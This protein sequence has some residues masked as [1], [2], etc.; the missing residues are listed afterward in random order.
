MRLEL[1][2]DD[3][4]RLAPGVRLV[5]DGVRGKTFLLAPEKAI[6]L[7]ATGCAIL[8]RIT[9]QVTFAEI[10][11]D[12]ATAYDAPASEIEG[13]VQQYLMALRARMYVG[14]AP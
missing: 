11:R 1:A 8:G 5:E 2:A 3:R 7:D 14:V 6:E 10:V 4:P 12:L 13:D 9:G